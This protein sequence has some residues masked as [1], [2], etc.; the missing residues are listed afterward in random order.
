M[1]KNQ[2]R[3]LASLVVLAV[4][5]VLAAGSA[6]TDTD[7]QKIQSQT[8][9]YELSANQLFREYDQNEVAADAKYKGK[10]V[11]V[12]GTIQNIG[13]DIMDEAYIVIGGAGFLDGVQCTFTKGEQ[14]SVARL[15]KGQQVRVKGEVAGRFGHVLIN[16]SSLQ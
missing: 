1:N 4:F 13:K 3:N 16:K 11:V 8:S 2:N 5:L 14:S 10:V 7:T 9:S 12:T 15:S 6:D